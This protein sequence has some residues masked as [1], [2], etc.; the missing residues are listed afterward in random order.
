MP[1]HFTS[2]Q[3]AEIVTHADSGLSYRQIS[4]KTNCSISGISKIISKYKNTGSL[5]RKNGS[6]RPRK[7][8]TRIDNI[9]YRISK[10]DRF[11][12]ANKIAEEMKKSGHVDVSAATIRRRLFSYGLKGCSAS[13]KIMI[14]AK[15]RRIRLCFAR[16]HLGWSIEDWEKILFSDESKFLC[17]SSDG[18]V[19]V[20]R[21]ENEKFHPRC[22][23]P[24]I[25]A[26]GGSVMVWG[27]M[28]AN[29]VG[30]LLRLGKPY[31]ATSYN[32]ILHEVVKPFSSDNLPEDFIFQQDNAPV[33]TARKVKQSLQ[34]LRFNV[35]DWPPQSPD[36]NV[37]EHLW[38][39]I[40]KHLQTIH[41]KRTDD[42]WCQIQEIWANISTDT[43]RKLVASMPERMAE[44]IK[45]EGHPTRY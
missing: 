8:T 15:N 12:T 14:S 20:R 25:Q 18:R 19:Y 37:I 22:T 31:N 17:L 16:A 40:K 5:M 26:G 43:C 1:K 42:L 33:H 29:G 32:T 27:C 30:P 7:T 35:M 24:T 21:F 38:G 23:K 34:Y 13:K 41:F 36:L 44:V 9:I 6:G 39:I 45:N 28:S 10:C 4:A 3:K 11:K 2:S